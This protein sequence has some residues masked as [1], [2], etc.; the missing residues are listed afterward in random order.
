MIF[1]INKFSYLFKIYMTK[2]T[3]IVLLLISLLPIS[4][5][6]DT[7]YENT[8]ELVKY[9]MM[10]CPND[11]KLFRYIPS[12]SNSF[13]NIYIQSIFNHFSLICF[14]LYDDIS[15]IKQ[16][17]NG[18]FIDFI[19]EHF[20]EKN[21]IKI[22][23]LTCGK[24]YYFLIYNYEDCTNFLQFSLLTEEH[25][26]IDISS[27]QN[28]SVF[29]QRE[30]K[31]ETFFYSSEETK[32]IQIN[33][34]EQSNLKIIEKNEKNENIIIE[35]EVSNYSEYF[36]FEKNKKYYIYFLTKDFDSPI[37]FK[38]FND[39]NY[40]KHNFNNGHLA[41]IRNRNEYNYEI[42]ISEYN[43][44]DNI[45]FTFFGHI[46]KI[47]L[48]YRYKNSLS[49]NLLYLGDF[50]DFNFVPLKI[51]TKD[52]SIIL[53]LN[54]N[55]DL[56]K[57]E[58]TVID[59]FKYDF[60]EITTEYKQNIKGPKLFYIDC[61]NFN[62]LNSFGIQSDHEYIYYEREINNRD[63]MDKTTNLKITK[64]SIST[65][66]FKYGFIY[67]KTEDYSS[68]E[69]KALN[70]PIYSLSTTYITYHQ[71]CI[72]NNDDNELYFYSLDNIIKPIFGDMQI[73]YIEEK[74]VKSI[75]DLD[76]DNAKYNSLNILFRGYLRIKCEKPVMFETIEYNELKNYTIKS[77]QRVYL[78]KTEIIQNYKYS[79]NQNLINETIPLKFTVFG[80]E[81][82]Q[83]ITLNLN[84]K[85]YELN[86][87]PLEINYL[88]EE[89]SEDLINF[90]ADDNIN[91]NIIIEIIVG[92]LQKDLVSYTQKD[93]INSIGTFNIKSK[94]GVIIKIPKDFSQDLYDYLII[95]DSQSLCQINIFYDKLEYIVPIKNLR[96]TTII[97]TIP[98]FKINPYSMIS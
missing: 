96:F 85:V 54:C 31:E 4:F 58:I 79:L 88:Y 29:F 86:N 8:D 18:D 52:T 23:N 42:D 91:E 43:I 71:L 57:N 92:F 34:F 75:S 11:Y 36:T 49:K 5:Q 62:N 37:S 63:I 69:V 1:L 81:N 14:Y 12:C 25:E 70:Y 95:F 97:N 28:Y 48:K 20:V 13:L 78:T 59:I 50:T 3:L 17:E 40:F 53:N 7:K 61:N 6:I 76:F 73:S 27:L 60:E 9:D 66:A 87:T 44:G 10:F 38:V 93:F 24:E 33:L 39:T 98:L 51:T 82:N 84:E 32:N 83:S 74:N 65:K 22:G 72:E 55:N 15:K 45:V 89:Y 35:Q 2:I 68:L 21:N 90:N 30:E 56:S 80:L 77:G 67:F 16:D 26:I 94:E 64:Q 19:Y 47:T 46:K 41:F